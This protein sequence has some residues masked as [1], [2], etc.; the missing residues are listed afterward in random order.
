MLCVC[1]RP[2]QLYVQHR[3]GVKGQCTW[4]LS[5]SEFII[6]APDF[7][8][9]LNL[10][11]W[12]NLTTIH[13]YWVIKTKCVKFGLI[14]ATLP[15]NDSN[16][17]QYNYIKHTN[18]ILA[19]ILLHSRFK[20]WTTHFIWMFLTQQ[21]VSLIVWGTKLFL[22]CLLQNDRKS[23]IAKPVSYLKPTNG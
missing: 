6:S 14:Q 7:Y 17:D 8:I 2:G 12:T 9:S 19:H 16:Q 3:D 11:S 10:S 13:K 1:M 23:L 18:Y 22:S 5:D 20:G 4:S 21:V 15:W